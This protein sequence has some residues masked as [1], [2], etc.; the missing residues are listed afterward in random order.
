MFI[1]ALK[2]YF[3]AC[4]VVP[5]GAVRNSFLSENAPDFAVFSEG[6]EDVITKYASG[7]GLYQ[8]VFSFRAR[9]LYNKKDEET[10]E[11]SILFFHLSNWVNEQNNIGNM[12]EI[13]GVEVQKIEPLDS[14]KIKNASVS[15]CVYEMK[16]RVVYYKRR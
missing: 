7:D 13:E 16:F 6:K 1:E 15:D 8:F 2:V 12:P 5:Y 4:P 10:K 9:L 14:G 11:N 3:S